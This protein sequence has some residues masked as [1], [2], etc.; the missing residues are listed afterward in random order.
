MCCL[1]Y[2][3][4]NVLQQKTISHQDSIEHSLYSKARDAESLRKKQ[5]QIVEKLQN[6]LD[7][8]KRNNARKLKVYITDMR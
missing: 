7:I 4:F 1:Y 5:V 2:T 6:D 3:C 8:L